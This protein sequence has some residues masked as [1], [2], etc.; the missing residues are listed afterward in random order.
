MEAMGTVLSRQ[1]KRQTS[2]VKAVAK[3]ALSSPELLQADGS[4]PEIGNPSIFSQV[5]ARKRLQ[6]HAVEVHR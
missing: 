1:R 4:S 5:A 6:S 2:L 3:R